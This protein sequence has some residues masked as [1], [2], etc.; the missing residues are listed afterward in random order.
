MR[1][2]I[3][4]HSPSFNENLEQPHPKE[5]QSGSLRVT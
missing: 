1:I 3:L 4:P 2:L 5:L